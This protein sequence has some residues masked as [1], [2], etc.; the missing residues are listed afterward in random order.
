[1]TEKLTEEELIRHAAIDSAHNLKNFMGNLS[2][3]FAGKRLLS[4]ATSEVVAQE[5]LKVMCREVWL[6]EKEKTEDG[7]KFKVDAQGKLIPIEG[8]METG[9]VTFDV[10]Q[11]IYDVC[12]SL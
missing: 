12:K 10:F 1:M 9:G 3:D 5:V 8:A 4:T 11:E 7:I 2:P 6:F